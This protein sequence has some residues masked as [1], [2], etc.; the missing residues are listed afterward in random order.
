MWQKVNSKLRAWA[1]QLQV[2]PLAARGIA[3][4]VH[5]AA[6]VLLIGLLLLFWVTAPSSYNLLTLA[7]LG[8][9][10]VAGA[11]LVLGSL[12]LLNKFTDAMLW[13]CLLFIAVFVFPF[14]F[15]GPLFLALAALA[16]MCVAALGYALVS[17][18]DAPG[19]KR[20]S[21]GGSAVAVLLVFVVALALDGWPVEED[22]RW[23]PMVDEPLQ[24]RGPVASEYS[25]TQFTYGPGTDT[26]RPAFGAGVRYQTQSVDASKLLDLSLI[27]I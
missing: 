17:P 22:I 21:A 14:A 11:G 5:I 4:A 24:I 6:W 8:L 16:G 23:Q 25:F 18:T 9:A 7:G 26:R 15:L 13:A 3:R 1:R 10:I 19:W 2:G 27:H 12:R 20:L